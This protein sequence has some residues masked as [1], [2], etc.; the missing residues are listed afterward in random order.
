MRGALLIWKYD[1]MSR[2]TPDHTKNSLVDTKGT[3]VMGM[4]VL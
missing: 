1:I 2:K 4:C 3:R